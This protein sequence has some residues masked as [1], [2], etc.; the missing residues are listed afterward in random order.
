MP[1]WTEEQ[2]RAIDLTGR[3]V[4]VSAAAGSGKTAVLVERT[5]NLL[6]DEKKG[7]PADSL[8]AVTFTNDAALQMREKLTAEIDSRAE[9]DPENMW[10]Q[11]Q[12]ALLRLAEI[13]TINSFCFG[14][15]KD[16]LSETDFQSG[17]RIIEENEA[18]MLCERA[19]TDILEDEYRERPAETEDLISKFCREND[20]ALRKLILRLHRF[21]RSLP[22]SDIWIKNTLSGLRSGASSE[23]V[24]GDRDRAAKDMI[25]LLCTSAERLGDIS[26]TLK[27]HA[28]SAAA[29][30]ENSLIAKEILDTLPSR[31][32][33]S[34]AEKLLSAPWK[35]LTG[36]QT[37][38][39]K[40]A[41]PQSEISAYESAKELNA[42]IKEQFKELAELLSVSREQIDADARLCADYFEKLCDLAKRLDER[43]YEMKTERNAV[44]FSDT[45]LLCVRLLLNCDENGSITRTPLCDEIVRSKRYKVILIDEFQDVN[46]LQEVIFKAISDTDDLS[47]I[48]ENVFLVGDVKQAIYRFRLANPMIF[49]RA[50][51]QGRDPESPVAGL[52]LRKNFRSRRS[53][54]DFCNYVFGA[55]MSSRV[56][57]T[58]YTDDEKLFCGA[59]YPG[60]DSPVEII[61][62]DSD[63][64]IDRLELEFIAAARRIRE[65]LSQGVEVFDGGVSRPCRPSDFCVLCRKNISGDSLRDIFDAEGLKVLSTESS[66]YLRSRE[67]SLLLNI[68][69]ITVDPMQDIPLASVM[70]SPIMGFSD[71]DLAELR[72]LDRDSKLYKTVLSVSSG[73]LFATEELKS[74]C[75]ALVSTVKRLAVTASGLDLSRLIRKIY[76]DTDIFALAASYEDSEQKCANL[77]LLLEY[78]EA[79][80]RS[81]NDGAAG[82]L[83]YIEY[84]SS[85]GG[86]FEQALTVTETSDAVN[87]K[88]IHRSK[89]LEFPFVI[90]LGT[91]TAFNKTDLNGALQLSYEHGAGLKFLDYSTLTKRS[92]AFWDYVREKNRTEL[93]SEELRLMYVA[94]TRAKERLILIMDF[95]EASLKRAESFSVGISSYSVPPS[96]TEKADCASDWLLMSLLK[97]PALGIIRSHL[98]AGVYADTGDLPPITVLPTP[99]AAEKAEAPETEQAVCDEA[100]V[101]ALTEE[102]KKGPDPRLTKNEA[103]LTVSEIVKD[104]ALSFFPRVPSLD[105]ELEEF[106]A[107]QKGTLT[108]RFMQFCDFSAAEADL[109]G[110]ILRLTKKGIFTTRE[111][112]AIDRRTVSDFFSGEIY[113]RLKKSRNVLREQRFIIRFDDISPDPAFAE[114][115]KGTEGMLQGVADCLFEEEDGYVLIDYKTDRVTDIYDLRDRYAPQLALYKAAFDVLLDKPVKAGYI[116]SFKLRR[117]VLV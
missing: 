73:E 84:I 76:D 61:A 116:Y 72:L 105:G 51:E 32:R 19:L 99:P 80:E 90:L 40:E 85:T 78:A 62:V 65:M 1:E 97:H 103:K 114:I 20:T 82:F 87:V 83:R 25:S 58:D 89:G 44:D 7:I 117:A 102:F 50:R 52:F 6:C 48:G 95:C 101:K 60:E 69:A 38:A 27:Y 46:N 13:T 21:L 2:K 4:V 100:L 28:S 23:E 42:K 9:L 12:Q 81:S 107:A 98:P 53:I 16:N 113:M 115:Y 29:L 77:Y 67:I 64:G 106:T 10:I 92:T 26:D 39:E 88:T 33:A 31:D 35:G 17:V 45:E 18:M 3:P 108:H 22:F 14:L 110:E 15:L 5:V 36:R 111:A 66:G 86:D 8:L 11:R 71:D 91:E 43:L 104:D 63:C 57:E 55:I 34:A 56:G 24:L 68:L 59:S 75:E 93:L 54:I 47:R 70:L 112:E 49:M 74:K 37:K 41:C 109:E 96:V 94:L 30:K 79:Y